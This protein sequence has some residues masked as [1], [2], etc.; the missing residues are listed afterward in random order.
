MSGSGPI[1]ADTGCAFTS[2]HF[3]ATQAGMEVLE[4]GGNAIDAMVSAAAMI[5]VAYP[6]MNGLGGDSF[7]IVHQ[8]GSEPWAIDASGVAASAALGA[9]LKGGKDHDQ[10]IQLCHVAQELL[11]GARKLQVQRMRELLLTI[12]QYEMY[13]GLVSRPKGDEFE[14]TVVI[15]PYGKVR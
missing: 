4:R 7:W 6:H 9:F 14:V 3:L 10:E 12:P 11:C 1:V 15:D 8:P 13:S 5:A 2:P